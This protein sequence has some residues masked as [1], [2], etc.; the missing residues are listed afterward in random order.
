MKLQ[1]FRQKDSFMSEFGR[2][3][4]FRQLYELIKVN[5]QYI[6]NKNIPHATCLFEIC[7]NAVSFM[8]GL[9]KS[10]PKELNLPSNLH[11]IVEK[12]SCDS[13]ILWTRNVTI[14]NYGRKLLK[15]ERSRPMM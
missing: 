12:F 6:Y 2:N 7:E 13:K 10:L 4:S 5:K 1:V 11:D 9:N 15:A 3:L 8:Q 14:V